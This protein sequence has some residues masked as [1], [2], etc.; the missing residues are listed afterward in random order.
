MPFGIPLWI[1]WLIAAVVFFIGEVLTEGF[2]LLW[3]SVASL[4]ALFFTLFTDNIFIQFGIFLVL[5]IILLFS[6]RKLTENFLNSRKKVESNVNALIGQKA[7]IIEEIDQ[8]EGFG[9]VKI[10]G[11][12]WKAILANPSDTFKVG[13]TVVIKD[14]DGVK[15]IIT[16]E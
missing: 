10:N 5:S 15:L 9:K 3:F 6:T 1:I 14:I 2:C 16:K 8:I 4:V 12:V 7:R 13:E 11:E